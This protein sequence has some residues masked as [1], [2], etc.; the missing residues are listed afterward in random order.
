M[1]ALRQQTTTEEVQ[2]EDKAIKAVETS[3]ASSVRERREDRYRVVRVVP[4]HVLC[5]EARNSLE[6]VLAR[7]RACP[8]D[9]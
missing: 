9:L 6:T 2:R 4:R 5:T 7:P 3:K 8:R 1:N